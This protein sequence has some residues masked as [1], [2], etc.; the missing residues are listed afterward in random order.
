MSRKITFKVGIPVQSITIDPDEVNEA[1]VK[2]LKWWQGNGPKDICPFISVPGRCKNICGD[3]FLDIENVY[4]KGCPF[5]EKYDEIALKSLV[6]K[7]LEEIG[8]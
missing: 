7:L 6:K 1:M 8:K 2:G 3:L 4:K 5:K